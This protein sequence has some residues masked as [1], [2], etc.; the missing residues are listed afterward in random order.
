[1][2]GYSKKSFESYNELSHCWKGTHIVVQTK[3]QM[4]QSSFFA[5]CKMVTAI[6]Q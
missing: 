1:V 6:A 3:E 5:T 4:K 2:E